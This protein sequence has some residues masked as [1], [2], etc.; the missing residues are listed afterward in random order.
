MSSF[1]V[2]SDF[3][4]KFNQHNK[5]FANYN[6]LNTTLQLMPRVWLEFI[7]VIGL[8]TLVLSIVLQEKDV[9]LILPIM[10]MF[11]VAT[12]RLI[13]STLKVINAVQNIIY[14]KKSV[15]IIFEDLKFEVKSESN[16]RAKKPIP[17]PANIELQG[18]M[19]NYP[20]AGINA[21]KEISFCLNHGKSLGIIG[22][23]GSGKSTL[24][25]VILGLL[26]PAS[27]K[28]N[29]N[30]IDINGSKVSLRNWQ[31][32]VGYVPQTIY[33]T[34]DTLRRNIAFGLPN[35]KI[36]EKS[37]EKSIEIAQLKG[38]VK[39]LPEG[40]NT[41]VG[42]RGVRLSGGQ[43]QRIG[44][45]RAIYHDPSVLVLDEA[46]SALDNETE[47]ALMEC[48]DIL[49]NKSKII[50]AHRLSTVKNCDIIIHIKKGVIVEIGSPDKVLSI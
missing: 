35:E 17:F 36:S 41:V 43:R 10:A 28:V 24:I 32:N 50:V 38:F 47:K 1:L 15:D 6:R 29:V 3:L 9:S 18:V 30:S 8:S 44:I 25:D 11:G 5:S 37:I 22:E 4:D 26:T 49:E 40:L 33:L 20:T 39:S 27:G 23:S 16:Q 31:D 7:A 21:L 13:P 34:D 48:I 12:I 14:N 46:T 45:A 42:E 2:E 19:F